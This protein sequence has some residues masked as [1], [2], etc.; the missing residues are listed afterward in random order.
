[1]EISRTGVG[2]RVAVVVVM[3]V[4]TSQ[5]KAGAKI[6]LWEREFW[7]RRENQKGLR[8]GEG[9]QSSRGVILKENA[10]PA[11]SENVSVKECPAKTTWISIL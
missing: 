6:A 2:G 11:R 4:L 7:V 9:F 3:G 5:D 1:M 10:E 8:E